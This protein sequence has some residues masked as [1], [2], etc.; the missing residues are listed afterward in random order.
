MLRGLCGCHGQPALHAL[1]PQAREIADLDW[2]HCPFDL[3]ASP[4]WAGVVRL[5]EL[6]QVAPLSGWPERYAGWAV[7][8]I[9]ELRRLRA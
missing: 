8:G 6:A 7:Q 2:S 3:L 9:L 5:D 1:P 4:F